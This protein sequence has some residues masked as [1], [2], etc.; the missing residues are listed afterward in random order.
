MSESLYHEHAGLL[1][2]SSF[3]LSRSSKAK[4]TQEVLSEPSDDDA[5]I[6]PPPA[7]YSTASKGKQP[8]HGISEP[9]DSP[10]CAKT[11]TLLVP[12]TSVCDNAL[13]V[14]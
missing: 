5:E 6:S 10:P 7:R 13:T 4:H 11:V 9:I 12:S 8:R 14:T 2:P 1:I 3:K